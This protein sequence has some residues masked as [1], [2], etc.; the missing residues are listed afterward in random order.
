[1][2]SFNLGLKLN[3]L[4][5][6]VNRYLQVKKILLYKLFFIFCLEDYL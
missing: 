1:M 3:Y 6:L 2:I 4:M 5:H